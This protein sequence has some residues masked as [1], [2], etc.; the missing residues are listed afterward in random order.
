MGGNK[1][2]L[3]TPT[4]PPCRAGTIFTAVTAGLQ[5]FGRARLMVRVDFMPM[6]APWGEPVGRCKR[7][8][9]F[10]SSISRSMCSRKST[11]HDLFILFTE[12]GGLDYIIDS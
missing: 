9:V 8:K 6:M 7:F 10:L 11:L 2:D 1:S 5:I 12:R 4:P 3:L